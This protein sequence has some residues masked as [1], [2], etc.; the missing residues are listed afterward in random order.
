MWTH[1]LCNRRSLGS[2]TIS[3]GLLASLLSLSCL[4]AFLS[5][6]C[7]IPVYS[8]R[9]YIPSVIFYW[10]F[11]LFFVEGSTEGL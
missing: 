2:Q 4:R 8:F 3:A 1:F 6:L 5:L 7:L 10:L 9:C 11:W